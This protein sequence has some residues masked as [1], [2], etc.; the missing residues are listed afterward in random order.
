MPSVRS[1]STVRQERES[2]EESTRRHFKTRPCLAGDRIRVRRE[3]V[4][5][6]IFLRVRKLDTEPLWTPCKAVTGPQ[7]GGDQRGRRPVD[8][9][10]ISGRG[11]RH[12][13]VPGSARAAPVRE[14]GQHEGRHPAQVRDLRAHHGRHGRPGGEERVRP[15]GRGRRL[16]PRGLGQDARDQA[17]GPRAR[18]GHPGPQGAPPP[19]R[20][21]VQAGARHHG[22][23]RGGQVVAHGGAGAAPPHDLRGRHP[24]LRPRVRQGPRPRHAPVERLHLV[25]RAVPRR[26]L[27]R[28]PHGAPDARGGARAQGR[29]P[30]GARGGDDQGRAPLPARRQGG[31]EDEVAVRRPGEAHGP[32]RGHGA[33]AQA[34][35]GRRAALGAGRDG[36]DPLHPLHVRVRQLPRRE[37]LPLAPPALVGRHDVRGRRVHHLQGRHLQVL[38]RARLGLQGRGRLRALRQGRAGRGP[39][40]ARADPG[41]DLRARRPQGR[42]HGVHRVVD[43]AAVRPGRPRRGARQGRDRPRHGAGRGRRGHGRGRRAPRPA[44]PRRRR[45]AR[46]RGHVPRGQDA[47]RQHVQQ[48]QGAALQ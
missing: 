40:G 9:R 28:Q 34:A 36:R 25:G 15:G 18:H 4:E 20:A 45:G 5:S 8:A 2:E 29:G 10:E 44:Q 47:H 21:H 39:R 7:H 6:P 3:P 37:R 31:H 30:R 1:A 16:P 14:N 32:R 11:G 41:Q 35:H 13:G 46:P 26:D 27:P 38:R 19:P 12:E 33:P 48:R 24:V 17:P 43:D 42:V 23:V 22:P